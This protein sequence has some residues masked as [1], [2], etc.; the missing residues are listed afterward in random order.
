MNCRFCS[1]PL[2]HVFID[3][4]EAPASNSFL[5]EADL[6]KP[7]PWY[8]LK[9]FV[10]DACFLVQVAEYKKA[11]EIFSSEYVYFSS[12]S[13]SWL[14][15]AHRYTEMMIQRFGFDKNSQVIEIA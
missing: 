6:M 12:Y 13:T 15:H 8:P 14:A 4:D 3:L 10:C 11:E 5:S 9:L 2:S 1:K 7:E